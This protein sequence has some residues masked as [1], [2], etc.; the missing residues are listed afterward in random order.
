MGS[1]PSQGYGGTQWAEGRRQWQWQWAVG[2]GSG[3]WAV[4]VAVGRR[5]SAFAKA[6]ARREGTNPTMYPANCC[7]CKE[8]FQAG[9]VTWA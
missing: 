6:S 1:P 3:Q 8:G 7:L 2:S 9:L 5:Q 4:A